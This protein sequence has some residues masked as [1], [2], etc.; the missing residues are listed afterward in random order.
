MRRRVEI[1]FAAFL[2]IAFVWAGWQATSWPERAALFPLAIAVPGAALALA[3]VAISSAGRPL[4]A[5]AEAVPGDLPTHMRL[6]R[7]LEAAGWIASSA[8]AVGALGF[9]LAV[10]LV[11]FLYL[12]RAG[13][14]LAPSVL[15]PLATWMFIYGLFDRLLRLPM[16]PGELLR[17]IGAA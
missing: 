13:E 6:G 10:P 11:S 14:P 5:A 16:P 17:L 2:A 12:R 15:I 7:S 3:Q 8:V 9:L 1:A 4:R